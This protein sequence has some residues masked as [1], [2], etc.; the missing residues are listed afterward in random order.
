LRYVEFTGEHAMLYMTVNMLTGSH[1]IMRTPCFHLTTKSV[2]Q[3]SKRLLVNLLVVIFQ[4]PHSFA[5]VTLNNIC[6]FVQVVPD[7]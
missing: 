2:W 7:V 6:S 5:V 1:A 3:S 4:H